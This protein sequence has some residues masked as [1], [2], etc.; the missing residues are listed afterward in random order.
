MRLLGL[1][2]GSVLLAIAVA[3]RLHLAGKRTEGDWYR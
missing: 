3:G 2:A 1:I